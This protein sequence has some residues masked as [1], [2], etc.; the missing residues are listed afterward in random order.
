MIRGIP[1]ALE[2]YNKLEAIFKNP[3][4]HGLRNIHDLEGP[5]HGVQDQKEEWSWD[6]IFNFLESQ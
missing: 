1:S 3:E 4:I 5:V 2:V 6:V